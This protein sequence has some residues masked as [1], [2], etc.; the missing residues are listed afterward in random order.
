MP[1]PERKEKRMDNM[2]S[3][4]LDGLGKKKGKLYMTIHPMDDGNLHVKHEM[5]G[6]TEPY[7]EGKEFSHDVEGLHEHIDAHFGKAG[8]KGSEWENMRSDKEALPSGDAKSAAGVGA[9]TEQ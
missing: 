7:D 1:A 3:K 8:K 2:I 5:R 9:P 4:A 6:G